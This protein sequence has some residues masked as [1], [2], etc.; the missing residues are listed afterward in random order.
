[1]ERTVSL[2]YTDQLNAGRLLAVFRGLGRL[3]GSCMVMTNMNTSVVRICVC[4][5]MAVI[6]MTIYE[7]SHFYRAACPMK[8]I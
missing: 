6:H 2:A 1:M 8:V 5:L 3:S 7:L 4:C